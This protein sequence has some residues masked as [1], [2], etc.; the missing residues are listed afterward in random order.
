VDL[1]SFDNV[2]AA[3]LSGL[4]SEGPAASV[5][6]YLAHAVDTFGPARL[7]VGSDWPLCDE[8][9]GHAAWVAAVDDAI[10]GLSPAEQDEIRT[11]TATRIYRLTP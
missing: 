3:K 2:V 9:A 1:A 7:T 10:T 8:E 5:G 4:F 6:R 11:G